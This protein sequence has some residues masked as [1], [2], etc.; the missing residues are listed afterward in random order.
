MIVVNKSQNDEK[1]TGRPGISGV[2]TPQQIHSEA[3]TVMEQ[4]LSSIAWQALDLLFAGGI[5]TVDQLGLT[6]RT[7]RRYAAK[8]I[9]DR[10]AFS[11]KFV[12]QKLGEY[13][14]QVTDGQLYTLGPVG[15]E[16]A[17]MRHGVTPASG[18]LAFTLERVLHDVIVNEIVQRIARE[19]EAHG[20]KTIWASKYEATVFKEGQEIQLLEPDAFIRLE[21]GEREYPFLIEYHNEDKRTRATQKVYRYEGAYD[22]DLWQETWEIAGDGFP[23]LLAVFRNKIVNEGYKDGIKEAGAIHCDYY[24]RTLKGFLAEGGLNDWFYYNKQG[25]AQVFPWLLD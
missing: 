21:Q 22:S 20:W 3:M 12:I 23:P 9:V 13:G 16:I 19:A 1:R 17:K 18:Y 25:K 14:L 10:Y 11:P 4:G 7:L 24:G 6:P 5:M 15:A 8:R 2:M